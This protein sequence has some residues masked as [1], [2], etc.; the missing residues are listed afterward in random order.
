MAELLYKDL[1]E[2]VISVYYRL[3]NGLSHT[4]PEFIYERAFAQQLRK[5]GIQVIRQDEYKIFYKD[6]LVGLQRL[7]L[8]VAREVVVEIKV[9]PQI[10][11]IH[12]AQGFSYLKVVAKQV[13]LLF[14][15]GAPQPE[16]ERLFYDI[17]KAENESTDFAEVVAPANQKFYKPE[18]V[19]E[20]L[21]MAIEVHRT[22]GSGFI[23]RIY[24]NACYHECLLRDLVAIPQR[25]FRVIFD[26]DEVGEIKFN[27]LCISDDILFFP[28]AVNSLEAINKNNIKAWLRFCEMKLA[29]LVNF[30]GTTIEYKIVVV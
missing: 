11:S 18:V 25:S 20:I 15:F 17:E 12:K 27:H 6:K 3:Y 5:L 10:L 22:L 7:D 16:F 28:I 13:G 21:K 19:N 2:K 4:Y 14:N 23:H 9:V 8:F 30:W 24:A 1:T 29:V 26:A